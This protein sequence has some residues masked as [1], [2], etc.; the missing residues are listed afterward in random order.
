MLLVLQIKVLWIN[1][2]ASDTH[3]PDLVINVPKPNKIKYNLSVIDQTQRLKD[4]P[5]FPFASVTLICFQPLGENLTC[6]NGP[7]KVQT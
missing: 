4:F 5:F 1:E 6:L 2:H 7:V 3:K